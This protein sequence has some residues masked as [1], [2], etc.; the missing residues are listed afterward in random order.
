[1]RISKIDG[2]WITGLGIALILSSF[3][4]VLKSP[5]N[6]VGI[7]FIVRGLLQLIFPRDFINAVEGE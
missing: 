5:L 6:I 7:T 2:A 4:E 3:F 1:M